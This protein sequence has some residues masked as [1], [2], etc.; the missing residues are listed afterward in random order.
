MGT[1]PG[2]QHRIPSPGPAQELDRALAMARDEHADPI[3]MLRK[4]IRAIGGMTKVL[5]TVGI[6]DTTYLDA[7]NAV[8][9]MR[10]AVLSPSDIDRKDGEDAYG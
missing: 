5:H 4:V 9:R 2:Q 8:A 1:A 10:L 7:I 6:F 3:E